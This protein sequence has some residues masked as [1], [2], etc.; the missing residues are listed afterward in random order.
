L[1]TVVL[2]GFGILDPQKQPVGAA[3]WALFALLAPW[4]LIGLVT[5]GVVLYYFVHGFRVTS[6][7]FADGEAEFRT[8]LFGWV[9]TANYNLTDWTSLMVRLPENEQDEPELPE[10]IA[11][12]NPEGKFYD[13]CNLWQVAFLNA[14]GEQLLAIE[15]LSKPEALWMA[16]VILRE[17]RTIR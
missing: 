2:E 11:K 1:A 4:I 14:A 15:N 12:G 7:I 8:A 3:W 13:G 5:I 17:Q 16:D 10:L 6:W 9:R